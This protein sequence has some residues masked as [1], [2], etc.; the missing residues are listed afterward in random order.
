M[1]NKINRDGLSFSQ[2]MKIKAVVDLRAGRITPKQ[3]AATAAS[4]NIDNLI[5]LEAIHD[6]K[7]GVEPT[8]E[9]WT[10]IKEKHHGLDS[11]RKSIYPYHKAAYP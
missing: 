2:R 7:T 4:F 1:A 10:A 5:I 6:A 3:F 8:F 9:F 11:L